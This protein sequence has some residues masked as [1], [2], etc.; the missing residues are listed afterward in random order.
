MEIEFY[1]TL[2]KP[3]GGSGF[4]QWSKFLKDPFPEEDPFQSSLAPQILPELRITARWSSESSNGA[5][6]TRLQKN[7]ARN[8]KKLPKLPVLFFL[9]IVEV[10]CFRYLAIRASELRVLPTHS[11]GVDISRSTLSLIFFFFFLRSIPLCLCAPLLQAKNLDQV[12]Q[13]VGGGGLRGSRRRYHPQPSPPL[14]PELKRD[15]SWKKEKLSR[16][17]ARDRRI[18]AAPLESQQPRRGSKNGNT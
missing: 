6:L 9:K 11:Q 1:V 7:N 5:K 10:S 4:V 16:W 2:C 18:I 13:Q 14:H 3:G 12:G 17:R 8:R 15:R